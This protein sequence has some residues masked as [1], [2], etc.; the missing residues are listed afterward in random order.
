MRA[1]LRPMVRAASTQRFQKGDHAISHA[2]FDPNKSLS[3]SITYGAETKIDRKLLHNKSA[4]LKDFATRTP[5]VMHLRHNNES[6]TPQTPSHEFPAVYPIR[7]SGV[8]SQSADQ[9][10]G[11]L[12]RPEKF[13][14]QSV[15]SKDDVS[16]P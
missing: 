7:G 6:F 11:H 8:A 16:S 2:A 14:A 10:C 12:S 4:K 15:K 5:R 13:L 3:R 9:G 1:H